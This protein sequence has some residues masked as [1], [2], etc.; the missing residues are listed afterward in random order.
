MK[1]KILFVPTLIVLSIF[2]AIHYIKPSFD[3]YMLERATRDSVRYQA[4]NI[5]K[6][7][8]NAQALK[9]E[10][11][12]NQDAKTLVERYLPSSKD[13]ARAIDNLNYLTAQSGMVT[14]SITFL[15]DQ[16]GNTA[17]AGGAVFATPADGTTP[18]VDPLMIAGT[19]DVFVQ[20]PY[21]R[22]E[23][24][25]F[26]VELKTIGTYQNIKDLLTKLQ[27]LD[28]LQKLSSFKIDKGDNTDGLLTLTYTTDLS[29]LAATDASGDAQHIVGVPVFQGNSLPLSQVEAI[30]NQI[31]NPVADTQLGTDG[32]AN[33][34]E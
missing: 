3:Q 28:R 20:P 15:A 7:T 4:E 12:Q 31:T 2:V 6:V 14:S 13:Q 5:Q 17:Q 34:F 22:P 25:S 19:G 27:G 1:T 21:V 23:A 24:Q 30:R 33:P 16:S 18:A 32:K 10:L 26:L 9:G 11:D 8:E 29:Y